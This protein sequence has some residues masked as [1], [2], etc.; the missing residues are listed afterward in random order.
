MLAV[1]AISASAQSGASGGST[2]P[3]AQCPTDDAATRRLMASRDKLRSEV[4][5]LAKEAARQGYDADTALFRQLSDAIMRLKATERALK[6]MHE[7][8]IEYRRAPIAPV[9]AHGAAYGYGANSEMPSGYMGIS[10]SGTTEVKPGSD[11]LIV[12][13]KDT[14]IIEAVEPGSPAER[15]GLES[16]DV[17]IAY[18]GDELKGRSVSLTRLLKPGAKVTVRVRRNGTTKEIPVIVGSRSS[19]ATAVSALRSRQITIEPQVVVQPGFQF[20]FE[21]NDDTI[22]V[23]RRSRA[24]TPRARPAEQPMLPPLLSGTGSAF[25]GAELTASNQALGE[26]F[27]TARG[28]IVLHVAEGTPAARAG[29]LVGDVITRIGD[30]QVA[31]PADFQRALARSTTRILDIEVLRRRKE[32]KDLVLK[33]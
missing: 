12:L 7:G 26:Y 15:A 18:N 13:Y 30:E 24:P 11:E 1:V 20:S 16:G 10:L 14:P 22:T 25:A 6:G 19:Y 17:I 2:A 31:K 29:I 21:D 9:P 5:R 28:I 23:T 3:C 33:W 32:K 8:Q 27:G 4:D